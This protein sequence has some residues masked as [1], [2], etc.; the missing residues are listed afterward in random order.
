MTM[1]V[2]RRGATNGPIVFSQ[3]IVTILGLS[4]PDVSLQEQRVNSRIK[5]C[6]RDSGGQCEKNQP[7]FNVARHPCGQRLSEGL[8]QPVVADNKPGAGG[9][10]GTDFV[11][12]APAD[13][14]TIL[15]MDPAIVINPIL[16]ANVQYNVFKDLQTISI[17]SSSP[18][19]LVVSPKLGIHSFQ[20]LVAYGKSHPSE[21]NFASAGIGTTPHLAGEMFIHATKIVA[22][23]VPYKGIGASFT[24]MMSGNV[25]MAFSSITGALPFTEDKRVIPLATTGKV[26]N[27]VYPDLPTVAEAGIPGFEVD[28][29][30]GIFGP[31]GL[32]AAILA[33]LN[34]ELKK[35]V[36]S[37]ETKAAFAKVGAEPR[38][39][40]P[41]EGAAFIRA[42][43]D[44]WTKVIR[45]AK[46]ELK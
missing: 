23:H 39:S 44:K 46:I 36:A 38:G 40:T 7:P 21:L 16:Q 17:I 26:R 27:P 33:R 3:F 35:V 13:G 6:A 45:D 4:A 1:L 22:T 19:V 41:E 20:D 2:M 11:A 31:A 28:L 43:Y 25:Q 15:I 29:W 24:D 12:H 32:P 14:Y 30:L 34:S 5:T 37:P 18:E 42:E 10:L 8:G 9:I